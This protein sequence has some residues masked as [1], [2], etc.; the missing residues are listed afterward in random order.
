MMI[1]G[2][3]ANAKERSY[4]KKDGTTG[5]A[6]EIA[7]ITEEGN[8]LEF[9]FG[10]IDDNFPMKSV[11]DLRNEPVDLE[12]EVRGDKYDRN[13]PIVCAVNAHPRD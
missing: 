3:L 9:G 5:T 7:F 1:Q 6:R 10:T 12:V 4:K 13:K 2:T 8:I 11:L